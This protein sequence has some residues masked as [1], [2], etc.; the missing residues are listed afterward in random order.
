MGNGISCQ[1]LNSVVDNLFADLKRGKWFQLSVR[2]VMYSES[3]SDQLH[4]REVLGRLRSAGFTMNNIY[5]T[6]VK[7]STYDIVIQRN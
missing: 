2:L 4:L 1:G 6:P 3:I 5:W 7:S